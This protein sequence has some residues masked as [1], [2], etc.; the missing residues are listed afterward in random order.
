MA[1]ANDLFLFDGFRLDRRN[2]GLFRQ[3]TAGGSVAVPVGSR[4]LDVLTV[5]VGRSGE[6]VSKDAI[7]NAVWPDVVIEEKNLTV[8]ISALRRLLDDGRKDGSCIQTEAGR[9][10]RFVSPVA[11]PDAGV[12]TIVPPVP[13]VCDATD[14][15]TPTPAKPVIAPAALP[16]WLLLIIASAGAGGLLVG[17]AGMAW[18]LSSHE[19]VARTASQARPRPAAYSPQDRRNSVIVLP[20]ENSSG[21]PAQDSVA[22]GITRDVTDLINADNYNP[23]IPA[24]MAAAYRGKAIDLKAIGREHDVHFAII[25]NARRESGRLIVSANVYGTTDGGQIWAKRFDLPDTPDEWKTIIRDISSNC[26]QAAT[27]SESARALREHPDDLDKRDLMFA[28][29]ATPLS[30]VSEANLLAQLAL[31]ERALA[32]DPDYVAAL[33]ERA[34]KLAQMVLHGF[35]SHGDRDLAIAAKSV[36]RALLIN[37]NDY[38]TLREKAVVLYAQRNYN[39]AAALLRRL[40]ER[41]PQAFRYLQLANI[42]MIQGHYSDASENFNTARRM[43]VGSDS[44]NT[45]DAGVAFGLLGNDRFSEAIEQARLAIT[46]FPPDSGRDGEHPWLILIAAEGIGGHEEEARADLN[47]F[48]ATPRNLRNMTELEKLPLYASNPKLLEGLRRAGMSAE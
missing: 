17:A 42:L 3:D 4:A 8:Q 10:Y 39:E 2:G 46:E 29:S 12:G 23:T 32:L 24:P 31:I 13:G 5:L 33:R 20:F 15:C 34:R 25:G 16:L 21:D 28:E 19:A 26:G 40:I 45:L 22:A 9:G 44:I 27:D 6:L 43:A 7:M 14:E 36:E 41:R 18:W 11:R 1:V 48:L 38:W 47:R 37:P 30:Q 35:S